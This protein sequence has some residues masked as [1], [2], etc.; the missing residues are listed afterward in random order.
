MKKKGSALRSL[1][2]AGLLEGLSLVVL[3]F[4][5]VPAKYLF[6]TPGMVKVIGPIHGG[7]FLLYLVIAAIAVIEYKWKI[8]TILLLLAASVIP[9]GC[10]YVEY[11]IIRPQQQKLLTEPVHVITAEP[12]SDNRKVYTWLKRIGVSGFIFFL[13]KGLVWIAVFA[14]LIK[15]CD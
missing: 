10:F 9:F 7:M 8:K 1:S 12:A 13:V 2:V 15:G 14:G 4:V 3:L 5:A 6:D 11:R